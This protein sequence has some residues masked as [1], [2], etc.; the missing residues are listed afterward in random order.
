MPNFTKIPKEFREDYN[1]KFN[2]IKDNEE[3]AR[4]SKE[5]PVIF[6]YYFLNIRVRLHQAYVIHKILTCK[7]KR[8]A[9][10][11]ARQLGKSIDLGLFL[12]WATWYNQFP[13]T[14]ARITGT[15]II[16]TTDE[17][18]MELLGKIREIINQADTH[19]EQFVG[20]GY[21]LNNM[22]EPNNT[23]QI[24]WKHGDFIKSVPP[25]R[26]V[27]GKSASYMIVDEAANLDSDE[28]PDV[29]YE[30]RVSPTVDETGGYI[31]LS[32]TPE[33]PLGF[34]YN[35]F[36]PE[37]RNPDRDFERTWFSF[38]IFKP[39]K[40]DITGKT[41]KQI[42]EKFFEYQIYI[43]ENKSKWTKQ[44]LEVEEDEL[45]RLKYCTSVINK[46]EK[47]E[48]EGTIKLWQQ[49]RMAMFTVTQSSFFDNEDIEGGIKDTPQLYEYKDT[50]CAAGYD[51]GMTTART[52]IT[53]R[54]MIKGEII[55]I[56]QHRCPAGFDNNKLRDPKW[57]HSIQRLNRRY[58]LSL[59]VYADDCPNGNDTNNWIKSNMPQV[60]L[61][62]YN[63][64]SDQMSKTDGI[65]RNCAAYSY[66]A[67]LKEGI[68]KLP[69]WNAIQISE[70]KIIQETL[71]K[72]LITIKAPE[73]QHCDTFDSDMM[74]C[75][76]FLDMKSNMD[77]E[78]DTFNVDEE[79]KEEHGLKYDKFH[80]P[81]DDECRQMIKDANEGIL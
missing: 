13:T 29:F 49:Q 74:A 65:N 16:S 28:D 34:F 41:S 64:R 15:Y 10:C 59:G 42:R 66:R 44:E 23:H 58:N 27:L 32:S 72:V 21:F 36:D 19:M 78:V 22:K 60:Q 24:T 7:K 53:I 18:A 76:P 62:L 56:F 81:S 9:L 52:V 39:N 8:I 70:M 67:R 69:K 37:D 11:W 50:P 5:D 17:T 75:I 51:Y 6:A 33:G 80:S 79:E 45:S 47:A 55:E 38:E 61:Y 48:R 46:K 54:T 20:T 14:V 57:E 73:G 2:P 43:N 26:K 25:T 12:I 63:F 71:Q 4:K 31:I 77:F 68:L 35:E 40:Y 30:K 1:K 3:I